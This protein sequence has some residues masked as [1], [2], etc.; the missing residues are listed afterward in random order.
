MELGGLSNE[1]ENVPFTL[2]DG[3]VKGLYFEKH[4]QQ[5]I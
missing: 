3:Y 4:S 5:D 2:E 1:L